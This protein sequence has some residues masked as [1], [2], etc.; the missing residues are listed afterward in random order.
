M[1]TSEEMKAECIKYLQALIEDIKT[2]KNAENYVISEDVL[3]RYTDA[4][5][6]ENVVR[7]AIT[8][9]EYFIKNE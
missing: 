5:N 1:K 9:S 4:Y 8:R 2:N 7:Y 6:T 3:E